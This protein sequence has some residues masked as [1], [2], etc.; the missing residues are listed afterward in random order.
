MGMQLPEFHNIFRVC[1]GSI[2]LM[3]A[4]LIELYRERTVGVVRKDVENFSMVLQELRKL[5]RALDPIKT[6]EEI[7]PPKWQ[8]DELLKM[9]EPHTE[10]LLTTATCVVTLVRP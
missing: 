3:N 8:R 4:L 9:I 2:L 1:G 6:F 5:I 7:G 10:V